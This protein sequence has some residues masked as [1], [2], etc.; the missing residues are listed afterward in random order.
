MLTY[1]YDE[2]WMRGAH[3]GSTNFRM[4]RFRRQSIQYNTKVAEINMD[5]RTVIT[6]DEE[7]F[8]ADLIIS[9]IPWTTF[10]KFSGMPQELVQKI[11]L[12]FCSDK[13]TSM[14]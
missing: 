12:R 11:S 1:M 13:K 8:T 2:T 4:F 9:S 14:Q 5:T 3:I 10:Q 7:T 6:L